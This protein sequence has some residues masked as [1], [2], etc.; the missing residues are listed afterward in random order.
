MWTDIHKTYPNIL[1]HVHS[2]PNEGPCCFSERVISRMTVTVTV[3]P[4]TR[5]LKGCMSV[6]LSHDDHP[7]AHGKHFQ[8]KR[9]QVG[10]R[11]TDNQLLLMT[12]DGTTRPNVFRRY[13]NFAFNRNPYHASR[14]MSPCQQSRAAMKTMLCT[15]NM[16]FV[17]RDTHRPCKII[18]GPK[19]YL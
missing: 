11:L 5:T 18:T 4:E 13:R 2:I 1:L 16:R 6:R 3:T 8:W 15:Y 10:V 17:I 14:A 12:F 9:P 7:L 19:R